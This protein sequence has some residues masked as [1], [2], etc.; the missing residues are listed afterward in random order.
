MQTMRERCTRFWAAVLVLSLALC[1]TAYGQEPAT[2]RKT[3][4]DEYIAKPDPTYA[5]KVVNTIPGDG[6][7]TFIVDMQSQSWL[8]PPKVDRA[9]WQHWLVIV[10][11]DTV[12]QDTAFLTIGGGKKGRPAPRRPNPQTVAFAKAT[13][14]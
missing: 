1:P 14:H 3:V 2:P 12:K 13:H 10:K 5:W 9:V 11:P 6:Y 4:L 7:T 8:A